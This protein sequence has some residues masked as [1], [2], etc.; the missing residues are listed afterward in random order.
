MFKISKSKIYY[1]IIPILIMG[2]SLGY[3]S[4]LLSLIILLSILFT[5]NRHTLAI[6]FV[7][8][9]AS[10][11]GVIR[12]A[13]PFIP[14]YGMLILLLGLFLMRDL[15][16]NL[17]K[18]HVR[19][20][21]SIF[22]TLGMFGI[23]YAIGPQDAFS[24]N[25]YFSMV[26]HGILMVVAF[27]AFDRS[28]N[29][30]TEKLA[31]LLIVTTICMYAF[32]I[33]Q[34]NLQPLGLFNY[35]WFRDQLLTAWEMAGERNTIITYQQI[36]MMALFGLAIYLSQ[37]QFQRG[38]MFFFVLCTAQLALVSGCR[39]AIVGIA[40]VITFRFAVF[41][42]SNLYKKNL[43][44]K[45]VWMTFGLVLAYLVFMFVVQ[46]LQSDY[47][48][49]TLEEGDYMRERIYE[50]AYGI[51]QQYPITGAGLGGYHSITGYT[52]PHNFIL[53]LLCETGLVGFVI[54]LLILVIPLIR[55]KQGLLHITVS[56]QFFFLILLG[57]FIRVMVSSDLTESIE[58]FSAV[59][60]ISSSRK[61]L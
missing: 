53:E 9:G 35:N 30:E 16:T 45:I 31:K 57:T 38:P 6:Y 59:F 7:M 54:S 13:Y 60:A 48:T 22:A 18:N 21:L 14:I 46:Y 32:V 55:N 56:N 27:F 33:G 15:V 58:L 42:L 11:G 34:A 28:K 5:T 19:A 37:I 44:R 47:I 49:N 52:Y 61:L 24:R 23:F 43:L 39:Q 36:G 8:Y 40:I 25:K 3:S 26:T 1:V 10:L 12:A 2:I 20:I 29:I 41:R 17:F 51:F 4:F 50:L